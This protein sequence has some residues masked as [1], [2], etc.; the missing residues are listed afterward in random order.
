MA[1]LSSDTDEMIELLD[2]LMQLDHDAVQAYSQAIERLDAEDVAVRRE[3][4]SFRADHERHV[5]DLEN[6]IRALGGEPR[7]LRRD[8]KGALLEAFTVLR[9]STGTLGAL[10][11]MQTNEKHTNKA[12]SRAADV[13]LP[14]VARDVVA[15]NFDDERR[16][17]AA[18]KALIGRIDQ[19]AVDVDEID[20]EDER[21]LGPEDTAD[22][23]GAPI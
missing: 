16:H 19:T 23:F 13:R 12:Y 17:L 20:T 8:L 1:R 3:L 2:D 6:A 15:R 5:A 7:E 21:D 22:R 9:S 18:I 11:A 4:E 10:E 14:L